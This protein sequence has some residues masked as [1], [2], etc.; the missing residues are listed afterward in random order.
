[1][2]KVDLDI[3]RQRSFSVSWQPFPNNHKEAYR[4]NLGVSCLHR[5]TESRKHSDMGKVGLD[6][7]RQSFSVSL[8]PLPNDHKAA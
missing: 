8:Q 1:M 6:I 7:Y 4:M 3:C 5:T 2:G